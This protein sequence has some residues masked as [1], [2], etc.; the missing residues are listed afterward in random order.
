MRSATVKFNAALSRLPSFAA[1]PGEQFMT[2]G[3]ID[4]TTGLDATQRAFERCKTGEAAVSFGEVYFQTSHDASVAPPDRHLIS[5][6]GQ[7]AP[8]DLQGGWAAERE[9]VARQFFD[10]FAQFA[11]DFEQCVESYEVL[12]PPDIEARVGL[13]GGN[14]F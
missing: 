5:I 12:G 8:Y 7:Y 14:I 6:F 2:R 4:L 3:T 1:A 13:A 11:P 10:L 9:G